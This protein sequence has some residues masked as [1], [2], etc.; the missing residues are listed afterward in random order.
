MGLRLSKN[1]FKKSQNKAFENTSKA[2]TNARHASSQTVDLSHTYGHHECQMSQIAEVDL[3][4]HLNE[5][6]K[7]PAASF[8]LMYRYDR[9]F[10]S[11]SLQT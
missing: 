2:E 4:T 3:H 6:R 7:N 9:L 1:R 11:G 8:M 10:K 5:C